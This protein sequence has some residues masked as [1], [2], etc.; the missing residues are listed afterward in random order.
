MIGVLQSSWAL[1]LGVFMLMIGNGVQGPLLGLR[2]E[3]AGFSTLDIS[4]VMSA[5]YV[6]FLFASRGAPALL[7]RVGHVRVFSAL[8]SLISA[9]LVLYPTITAPWAWIGM[10][11][12]VGFCFC[13]VYITAESWLNDLASNQNRG[14]AL[15]L[16]MMAQMAGIVLAQYL[17][18]SADVQGFIVFIIPSVLVSMSF[19]PILLSV[20]SHTPAYGET[21]PLPLKRLVAA[22]PLA[23]TGMFFVGAVFSAFMGMVAIYGT[24]VGLS[25]PQIS[26]LI[27]VAYA[28]PF[29]VQYPIGWL[30]DQMDRRIL[31]VIL[32]GAG[33]AGAAIGTLASGS[34][35]IA[36]L[37]A[38]MVG[39]TANALYPLLSAHA[40]DYLDRSDMAAAAGGFQFVSGLGSIMGPFAIGW[41]MDGVGPRGFWAVLVLLLGGVAAFALWRHKAAPDREMVGER[42]AFAPM[43]AEATALAAGAA[44]EAAADAALDADEDATAAAGDERETI[45]DDAAMT[46]D[47]VLHFWLDEIGEAGW[48]QGGDE[49]DARCRAHFAAAWAEARD[50]AFRDW[51][52][53]A[54]GTLAYLVLTDQLP[55]NM[56]RGHGDSFATDPLALAAAKEAVAKGFDLEIEPPA[57]Q[58]FYL[59]FEHSED[60]SDQARAVQLIDD[61]LPSDEHLVHARAH[62]AVIQRFGRFPNRNVALGREDTD[63]EREWLAQGGYGAFA[64]AMREGTPLF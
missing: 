31:V 2:G 34:F 16:Y 9:I 10:R 55:R 29:L 17:L 6:G 20:T 13:G 14:K 37:A 18:A 62:Q 8:G 7:R 45:M 56:F 32:S 50:G 60:E 41:A 40:N 27:A 30:S 19:A 46:P 53:D 4:M 24:R 39:A 42:G 57:R 35:W 28:V 38:A 43:T 58:F 48:Y 36:C 61:R 11:I 21:K 5:Y 52:A 15:S 51:L 54:R 59:P 25:V 64:R 33:A 3:A 47:R 12:V 63:E 23:V 49:I 26:I 1:L 22:S 44:Q